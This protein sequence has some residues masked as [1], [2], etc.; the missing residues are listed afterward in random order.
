M[1]FSPHDASPKYRKV[2]LE[3]DLFKQALVISPDR[4]FPLHQAMSSRDS[5]RS[6]FF[7]VQPIRFDLALAA[8]F[9]RAKA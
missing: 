1:E 5:R 2:G 6:A 3:V 8:R 7:F 9:V 4:R